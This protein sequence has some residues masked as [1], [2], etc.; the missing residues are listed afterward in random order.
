MKSSILGTRLQ[1]I[2]KTYQL[3]LDE[4]GQIVG[5][6][7]GSLSGIENGRKPISLEALIRIADHFNVSIDYLLGRTDNPEINN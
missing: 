7:K 5:L 3:S 4:L 1:K 6:H 2:R